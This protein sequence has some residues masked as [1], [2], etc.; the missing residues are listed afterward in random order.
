MPNRTKEILGSKRT[1][2]WEIFWDIYV[3]YFSQNHY[4]R[5]FHTLENLLR[6]RRKKVRPGYDD[7]ALV[8]YFVVV[9]DLSF[10]LLLSSAPTNVPSV[11]KALRIA[12]VVLLLIIFT[13]AMILFGGEI[14]I[15]WSRCSTEDSLQVFGGT[16]FFETVAMSLFIVYLMSTCKLSYLLTKLFGTDR[17]STGFSWEVLFPDWTLIS[18]NVC[19]L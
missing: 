2:D 3:A 18:D 7:H 13:P 10:I 6:W 19:S 17:G 14:M 15:A 11:R 9:L 4:R 1:N 12:T 8:D 5:T 16:A